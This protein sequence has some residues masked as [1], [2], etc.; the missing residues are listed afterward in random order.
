MPSNLLNTDTMFPT[1]NK[2]KSTDENLNDVLNYL[3]MLREQLR[4]NMA[5]LDASNFN[6]TALDELAVTINK[7]LYARI[8]DTEGKVSQLSLDAGQFN[9][10]LQNAEG[11]IAGL[12]A[13]V[14]EDS[15][16]I[17]AIVSSTSNGYTA[18]AQFI[19][20]AINGQS[21][22]TLDA[23]VINFNAT[24]LMLSGKGGSHITLAESNLMIDSENFS[25]TASGVVTTKGRIGIIS[26]DNGELAFL[27]TGSNII[28]RL[29]YARRTDTN[30]YALYL[31]TS[32]SYPL[33][34]YSDGNMSIDC[35][36]NMTLYIGTAYA[37]TITIGNSSSN[38]NIVGNVKING[39]PV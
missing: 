10:R 28:G 15:A 3:Y 35:K 30:D 4:Y 12:S 5:N 11:E 19:L 36:L 24:S 29:S 33:K 31:Q 22:A 16:M 23:D 2:N 13:E 26:G 17:R 21:V 32:N 1:I 39:I 37:N 9:L 7:P 18:N 25:V 8:E 38:V 34:L 27:S 20:A 6:E 14:G